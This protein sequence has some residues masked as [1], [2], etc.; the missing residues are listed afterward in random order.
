[1]G[2]RCQLETESLGV[3]DSA[4]EGPFGLKFIEHVG[5]NHSSPPTVNQSPLWRS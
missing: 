5:L 4:R 3:I 1:M 2:L